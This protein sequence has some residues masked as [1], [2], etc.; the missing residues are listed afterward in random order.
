MPVFNDSNL[1]KAYQNIYGQLQGSGG[2]TPLSM[3]EQTLDSITEQLAGALRPQF[4][5]AIAQRYGATKEQKA[6]IDVDAASRGMGSSTWVTDAKNRIMNAEAA[7]IAGLES[8]YASQLA[9]DA[10]NQYNNYLG[11]KL[12]LDQYNQKL[13]QALGDDAYARTMQQLSA[14]LVSPVSKGGKG[15]GGGNGNGSNRYFDGNKWWNS[16]EEYEVAMKK[17]QDLVNKVGSAATKAGG[18]VADI[19]L[20]MLQGVVFGSGKTEQKAEQKKEV[21]GTNPEKNIAKLLP[22]TWR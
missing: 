15:G 8:D 10:L 14:G 17:E 18:T 11:D 20:P 1:E 5:R 4:E 21:G 3:P 2:Y 9:G 19:M 7:D 6:R 12:A 22:N 13:A 16:R